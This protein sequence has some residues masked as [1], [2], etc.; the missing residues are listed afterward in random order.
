V[1]VAAQRRLGGRLAV[2]VAT[3]GNVRKIVEIASLAQ[4][5]HIVPSLEEALAT[6]AS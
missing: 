4:F 3:D 2:V 1:L 5:I 6:P